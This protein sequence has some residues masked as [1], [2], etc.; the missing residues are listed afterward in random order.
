MLRLKLDKH[1]CSIHIHLYYSEF[2]RFEIA[3]SSG[4]LYLMHL[5]LIT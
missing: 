1:T 5:V 3:G 2:H 4:L